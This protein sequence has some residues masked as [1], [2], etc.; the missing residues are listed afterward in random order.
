MS[1][2]LV[3]EG[4]PRFVYKFGQIRTLD[5]IKSARNLTKARKI[6][7]SNIEWARLSKQLDKSVEK[8]I[9]T[10]RWTWNTS[11]SRL[12]QFEITWKQLELAWNTSCLSLNLELFH[13]VIRIISD[14]LME[15]KINISYYWKLTIC[16]SQVFNS[17]LSKVSAISGPNLALFNQIKVS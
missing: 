5:S 16:K 13:C 17:L 14:L 4:I 2:K 1:L 10:W 9:L 7:I 8:F 15:L 3:D 6:R 11:D 12:G